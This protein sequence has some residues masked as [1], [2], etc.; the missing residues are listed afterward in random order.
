MVMTLSLGRKSEEVISLVVGVG[1]QEVLV[2]QPFEVGFG[3]ESIRSLEDRTQIACIP[4]ISCT[5]QTTG[6][7]DIQT[8]KLCADIYR[9]LKSG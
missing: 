8:S 5:G 1:G 9:R 3:D 7:A 4:S 2:P 6:N